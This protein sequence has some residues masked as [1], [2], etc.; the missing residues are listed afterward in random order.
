MV[1]GITSAGLGAPDY[2]MAC[3]QHDRYVEALRICGLDVDILPANEDYPDSV[4]IEDVALLTPEAAILTIPGAPSRKGEATDVLPVIRKNYN[5]IQFI[6][7]PGTI[8]PGDIMMVGDHYYIGLSK[9]TNREGAEQMIR[10]L[11]KYNLSG[12]LVDFQDMLHLKTGMAYLEHN[13]LLAAGEF[14]HSSEFKTF[15]IIEVDEQE[16]YAANC[17]WVNDTVILAKGYPGT[18]KKIRDSGY[19][20]LELDMSEFQKLDGGLSCLSLRF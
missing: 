4:F 6:K 11:N 9:R 12:S 8:E 20:T 16:S 1:N 2:D 13:N 10:I 3:E 5:N 17:I 18:Q 7:E 15:N 19:K 14:I